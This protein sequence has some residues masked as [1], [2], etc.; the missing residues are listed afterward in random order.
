MSK[1]TV[2]SE[3]FSDLRR[4]PVNTEINFNDFVQTVSKLYKLDNIRLKVT[5][6]S[7]SNK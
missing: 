5:K 7:F 3:F 1:I 2:K 6:F 4:F